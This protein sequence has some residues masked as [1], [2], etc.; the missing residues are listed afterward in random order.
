MNDF[1]FVGKISQSQEFRAK[2]CVKKRF[3]PPQADGIAFH[4]Y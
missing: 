1:Q 2:H 4:V 3:H